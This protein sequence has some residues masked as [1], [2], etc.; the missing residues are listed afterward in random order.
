MK[1]QSA[2]AHIY[3]VNLEPG[4]FAHRLKMAKVKSLHKR[5]S[6]YHIGNYGPVLL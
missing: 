2:S 6:T 3:N 1:T 5:G 4:I